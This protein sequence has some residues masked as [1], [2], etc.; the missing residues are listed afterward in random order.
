MRRLVLNHTDEG[1]EVFYP[2]MGRG[3]TGQAC[4]ET[5]RRF[6]GIEKNREHYEHAL[7]ILK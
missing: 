6:F 1:D 4:K 7:R 5:G 2:F 3:T